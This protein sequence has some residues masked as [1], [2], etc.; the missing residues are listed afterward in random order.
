MKVHL[1]TG[2]TRLQ[3]FQAFAHR[4]ADAGFAGMVVTESGRTA[5][6]ACAAAA[7]SGADLDLATGVASWTNGVSHATRLLPSV[8]RQCASGKRPIQPG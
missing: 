8:W 5:Y 7:L 3:G 6:L 2:A 1:M 4:C